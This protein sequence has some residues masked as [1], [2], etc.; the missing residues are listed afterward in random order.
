[1]TSLRT[2]AMV[3]LMVSL[4]ACNGDEDLKKQ[5]GAVSV[6]EAGAD[7]SVGQEAGADQ[8]LPDQLLPDKMLSDQALPDKAQTPL[9][10]AGTNAIT[11][12]VKVSGITCDSSAATDC[13]GPLAV[14]AF[15]T[16]KPTLGAAGA[17]TVIL[18]SADLGG[19]KSVT[20]A[21]NV[22]KVKTPTTL[23]LAGIM[24]DSGSLGTPPWPA[25]G[26]ITN[27]KL[28]VVSLSGSGP[29]KADVV[30]DARVKM[31]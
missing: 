25:N 3:G 18:A 20:Y 19:G 26:H 9:P 17:A 2:I 11:G 21:L 27:K 14:V 5:D 1:M 6:T 23:Y 10:D 30:L 24:A 7:Q 12:T 31:K 16:N 15:S 28:I 22:S 29:F 13:K 8:A 4:G